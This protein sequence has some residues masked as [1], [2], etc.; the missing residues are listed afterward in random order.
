MA[1]PIAETVTST[2]LAGLGEG[3][4]VG[5]DDHR[6][7]IL[8]PGADAGRQLQPKPAG[9]AAHR[10][11]EVFEVV[12]ARTVE[13]DDDP[14]AGQLVRADALELAEVADALGARRNGCSDEG[15]DGDQAGKDARHG[16]VPQNGEIM[17]KKL[18][19]QPSRL[20]RWTAPLAGVD[21][22]GIGHAAREDA[23]VRVEVRQA[24]DPGGTAP[25]PGPG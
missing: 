17:L 25:I 5:G 7:G 24:D 6:R 12:V 10:L 23:V 16:R 18:L 3:L 8:E 20:A 11:G 1:L 22:P 4:K 19:S 15:Q 9:H 21:D 14:V 2:P 13:P